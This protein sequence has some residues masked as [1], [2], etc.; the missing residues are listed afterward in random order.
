MPRIAALLLF[1]ILA[2]A[3]AS[4]LDFWDDE[5]PGPLA[6][7]LTDALSVPELASQVLM[8]AFADPV[9]D[10]A[11]LTWVG[12]RSLGGVKFFGWNAGTPV[13]V[14][15]ASAILQTRSQKTRFRIPLLVAT[16]QEGGWVRHIKGTTTSTPG[17]LSL[18]AA[19]FPADAW[20]TGALL[21]AEL[22]AMGVNMNFAPPVDLY[23]NPDSTVIGPRSFGQDP[24]KVGVLG[25]AFVKGLES[26]GVVAT[27]KHFPGHGNTADDSH[28]RLPV[29][30]D[31]R[32]T[33]EKREL[34]P[35]KMM[36]A[37]G[38][39]AIMS[40]HIAFPEVAGNGLPASLS[41]ALINGLL[42]RDLG[43]HGVV[44]TDDLYM[45][46]ARPSGWSIATA[47]EKALEAGN[48]LLLISKP[49]RA[50]FEAWDNLVSRAGRDPAFLAS[51]KQAARRVIELKLREL[52]GPRAVPIVPKAD[53]LVVPA[54]GAE[55]FVLSAT[56]RG[57][58]VLARGS[59]P[60]KEEGGAPLV[61]TPYDG[62]WK[63]VAARFPG[64]AL[65]EYE[66][67][68]YGSDAAVKQQIVNRVAAAPRTVF[69]L[70][71][72]GSLAYLKALA[73]YRD[74]VAVVSVL[75]PVYLRDTP[76]VKDAVAVYGTNAA[77]FDVAAAVLDGD[78]S[79]QGKLP[80]RFG[81]FP[82]SPKQP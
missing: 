16:D 2:S 48:D 76:W 72:P 35:Y 34:V 39:G 6:Q 63:S 18:G 28:G 71:T 26:Q 14:A 73:P 58:T 49:A 55:A 32:A 60:W 13:Q 24:V 45:E 4:A 46:G 59:L 19:D 7:K 56:A 51:L 10:E 42:R 79:P 82:W 38:L 68:F 52:K 78:I 23:T 9:P 33:L 69:V 81:D 31:D 50:Q 30:H 22:R 25:M 20:K 70:A 75:S 12:Q 65:V 64:A 11:I 77:A 67:D 47:A 62:A 27:A 40:G 21:G 17:N 3:S 66:Y 15:Q 1:T 44:L 8:L 80:L 43:F 5:A 37:D 54:P 53:H 74:K 57:A 41:P 61:V 36:I 29:I